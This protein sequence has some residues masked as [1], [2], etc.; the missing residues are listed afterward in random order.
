MTLFQPLMIHTGNIVPDIVYMHRSGSTH[1]SNDSFIH[2]SLWLPDL[3][4]SLSRVTRPST[5]ELNES[6]G[7]MY[8]TLAQSDEIGSFAIW[9]ADQIFTSGMLG[10]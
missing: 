6:K 3:P 4:I 5:P 8:C 2:V 7:S 9:R 10:V 1:P